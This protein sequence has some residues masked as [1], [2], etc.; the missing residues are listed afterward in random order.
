ML[1]PA[2]RLGTWRAAGMWSDG[3]RL[4][5]ASETAKLCVYDLTS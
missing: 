5:L 3:E 4:Y 2:V 1:I